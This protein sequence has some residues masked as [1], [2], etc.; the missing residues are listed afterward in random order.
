M[1]SVFIKGLS[2]KY[3]QGASALSSFNLEVT[4][5]EMVILA[6]PTGSGKSTAL[7]LISGYEVPTAGDIIINGM[8][9]NDIPVSSRNIATVLNNQSLYPHMTVEKNLAFSLRLCYTAL[10]EISGRIHETAEKMGMTDLLPVKADELDEIQT[11]Q[12][13]LLRAVVRNPRVLLV[14][15]PFAQR[16][17]SLRESSRDFI[18]EINRRLGTT[19]ILATKDRRMLRTMPYKT[20]II[21]DG[22][23]QQ[24]DLPEHIYQEP[25]NL[26]VADFISF[27][28]ME[29]CNGTLVRTS[30]GYM[31]HTAQ[32][33]IL[34]DQKKLEESRAA[35]YE[36]KEVI[37]GFRAEAV[38]IV[39]EDD[40]DGVDATAENMDETVYGSIITLHSGE[41]TVRMLNENNFSEGESVKMRFVPGE[42]MLFDPDSEKKI[43]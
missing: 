39:S 38:E 27:P 23:I 7:R 10:G 13:I 9:V 17:R 6:G 5:G 41:I 36:G 24:T 43:Y 25:A 18:M 1:S 37:A 30:Q 12:V 11:M 21:K 15:M 4:D 35:A 3:E 19:I 32:H 26:F 8:L 31:L 22:Y 42:I 16:S 20:V 2:K 40:P 28:Q 34:L 29:S 14:D 33:D